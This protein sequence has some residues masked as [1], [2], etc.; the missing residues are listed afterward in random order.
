[1]FFGEARVVKSIVK[2]NI[3]KIILKKLA[4]FKIPNNFASEITDTPTPVIFNPPISFKIPF[5]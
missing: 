2:K 5:V 4:K 3:L 1:M